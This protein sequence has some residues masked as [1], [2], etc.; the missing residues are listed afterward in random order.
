MFWN[1]DPRKF[2]I[3]Q[4]MNMSN[5]SRALNKLRE[6][7]HIQQIDVTQPDISYG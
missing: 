6:K 5:V 2:V 3:E 4:D 1:D 7:Y